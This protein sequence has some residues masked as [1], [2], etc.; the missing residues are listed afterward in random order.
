[1]CR[2]HSKKNITNRQVMSHKKC[3]ED[4]Q[5]ESELL[6]DTAV[7]ADDDDIANISGASH[8]IL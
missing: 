1:M 6:V 7:L 8:R 5:G 2:N 4:D 3:Q